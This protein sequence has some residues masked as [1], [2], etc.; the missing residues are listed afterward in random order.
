MIPHPRG[1]RGQHSLIRP[2]EPRNV[3]GEDSVTPGSLTRVAYDSVRIGTEAAN[4]RYRGVPLRHLSRFPRAGHAAAVSSPREGC[5]WFSNRLRRQ[6]HSPRA[7][8]ASRSYGAGRSWL[9][10]SRKPCQDAT[11]RQG[12]ATRGTET[13]KKA[14]S[15]LRGPFEAVFGTLRGR[16]RVVGIASKRPISGPRAVRGRV[17]KPSV[18]NG[19]VVRV[20]TVPSSSSRH[21][22][23]P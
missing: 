5:N 19:L 4:K 1:P 2:V 23:P 22:S 6:R 15:A 8:L 13:G 14:P 9:A 17:G 11:G 12:R 20:V 7:S 18:R 3:N 16:L 10:N 21:D